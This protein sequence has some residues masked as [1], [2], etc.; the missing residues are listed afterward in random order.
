MDE[1]YEKC[2]DEIISQQTMAAEA[3]ADEDKLKDYNGQD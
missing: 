2:Y 1:L 3:Q